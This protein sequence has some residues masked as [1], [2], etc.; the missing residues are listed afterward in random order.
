MDTEKYGDLEFHLGSK[1]SYFYFAEAWVA[2]RILHGAL[3]IR[4]VN[5]HGFLQYLQKIFAT[6]LK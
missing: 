3:I 2:D 1:A 5:F 6:S 4:P